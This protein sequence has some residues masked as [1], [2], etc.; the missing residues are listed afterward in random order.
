MH[1]QIP[2]IYLLISRTLYN[3]FAQQT[4]LKYKFDQIM[5]RQEYN[6]VK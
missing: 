3:A 2:G 1:E 6:E 4:N 5:T